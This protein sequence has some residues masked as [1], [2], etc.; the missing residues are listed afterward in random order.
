MHELGRVCDR[1]FVNLRPRPDAASPTIGILYGWPEPVPPQQRLGRS[2]A[3]PTNR[4]DLAEIATRDGTRRL[5]ASGVVAGLARQRGDR[6]A[7][8]VL[9]V[10]GGPDRRCR[11]NPALMTDAWRCVGR[12]RVL[13]AVLRTLCKKGPMARVGDGWA[14]Y[15]GGGRSRGAWQR[16]VAIAVIVVR[17]RGYEE[18]PMQRGNTVRASSFS[19]LR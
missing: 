10:S 18:V 11:F 12:W 17:T 19:R 9:R 4:T 1:L 14:A 5:M 13:V 16:C 8:G 7:R 2:R 3:R 6:A 15:C